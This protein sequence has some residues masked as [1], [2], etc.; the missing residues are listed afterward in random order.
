M[1]R[2]QIQLPDDVHARARALCKRKEISMAELARRG[3]E[4]ILSVYS[5][6]S[7][8]WTPPQP[9]A[10]GWKGL[11]DSEIKAEAQQSAA[12]VRLSRKH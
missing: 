8:N 5:E 9:R 4:F 12:E 3:I 11:S 2:T 7:K 1:V 6:E 10:L